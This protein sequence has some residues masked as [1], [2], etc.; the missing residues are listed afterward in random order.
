M[1]ISDVRVKLINDSADRLKAVCTV[2]FDGEF[3]VRDVKVVDGTN[4]LFVAMPSRKLSVHC[5]KCRHKNH[6]RSR[7]CN[8]CGAR[9]PAGAPPA[10]GDGRSRMHRDIAHPITTAFR[11]QL[12][13]RVIEAFFA[14]SEEARDPNYIAPDLDEAQEVVQEPEENSE[15]SE[16]MVQPTGEMTEYDSIIAGLRGGNRERTFAPEESRPRG[17]DQREREQDR[18]RPPQGDGGRF[19]ERPPQPQAPRGNRSEP[20]NR[21]EPVTAP[22]GRPPVRPERDSAYSRGPAPSQ[23]RVPQE[24]PEP[25]ERRETTERLAASSAPRRD[26]RPAERRS[27]GAPEPRPEPSPPEFSRPKPAPVVKPSNTPKPAPP[28]EDDDGGFGAGLV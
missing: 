9:L 12:Q 27:F 8:D 21:G 1:E 22:R 6:L 23:E 11:E 15:D 26:D 19:R 18:P 14:E 2:T 5:P 25:I 28:V 10:E 17:R 20:G 4:G 13:A 24:R 3:V 7:F 16:S